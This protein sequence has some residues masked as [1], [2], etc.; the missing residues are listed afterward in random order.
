[1]VTSLHR[2]NL[3]H[4]GNGSRCGLGFGIWKPHPY[5]CDPWPWHHG[6]TH[7]HDIPY[8]RQF[9]QIAPGQYKTCEILFRTGSGRGPATSKS[10]LLRLCTQERI[11]G[12]CKLVHQLDCPRSGPGPVWPLFADPGPGPQVQVQQT[13]DLDLDQYWTWSLGPV[14]VQSG[15]GLGPQYCSV[16]IF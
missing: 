14:Q 15:S 3:W 11:L 13:P 10:R 9:L 5:P 12:Q 2:I 8:L 7:T 1:M 4:H 16:I 6:F